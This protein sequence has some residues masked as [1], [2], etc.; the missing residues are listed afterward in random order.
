MLFSIYSPLEQFKCLPVVTVWFG[1]F[2]IVVFSNVTLI[3]FL[4]FLLFGFLCYFLFSS[5]QKNLHVVPTK[6]QFVLESFYSIVYGLVDSNIGSSGR[7]FFPYIFTIFLFVTLTNVI[8]LVPYSFTVT[9]HIIITFSL[10]ICLFVGAN[11][12]S[13]RKH[14]VKMGAFFLPSGS[15]F[16]LALLLVPIELVSFLFRPISLSVRLFANMMAG[17]ALLKV[18]ISFAW[19]M[20]FLSGGFALLHI[21]PLVIIVLL[22][23][24]EFGVALIQA[25]VFTILTCIY[26]NDALHLH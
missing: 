2:P 16:V 19:T 26:I 17:H 25:Y 13:L 12:I 21:F 1:S 24:L 14:G 7:P 22:M 20:T 15:P 6:F 18:I 9:S 23:F 11:I 5:P 10:A 8:G 3:L 4:V